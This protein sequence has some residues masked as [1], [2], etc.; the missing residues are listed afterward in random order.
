[1][2]EIK[3]CLF[4]LRRIEYNKVRTTIFNTGPCLCR[5]AERH[6]GRDSETRGWDNG[7]F[8]NVFFLSSFLFSFS[9]KSELFSTFLLIKKLFIFWPFSNSMTFFSAS[10]FPVSVS[11][12]SSH[13]PFLVVCYC[14]CSSTCVSVCVSVCVCV[15]DGG[16]GQRLQ[17]TSQY[18]LSELAALETEQKH[19]DSRAAVVERRL[20]SLMETGELPSGLGSQ[21]I[22]RPGADRLDAGFT[23]GRLQ[24]WSTIHLTLRRI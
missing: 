15:C 6:R 17:D 8:W 14:E 18:V 24:I 4:I 11:V 1:M 21:I 16:C 22:I 9:F 23:G 12:S 20:R 19:I 3:L 5:S 7:Q 2:S 10:V 13:F